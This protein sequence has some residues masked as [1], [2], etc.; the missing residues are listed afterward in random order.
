M[1]AMLPLT[2]ALLAATLLAPGAAHAYVDPGTGSMVL[3]G[4]IAAVLGL[5]LTVKLYWRKIRKRLTGKSSR[6][7]ETDADQ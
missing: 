6:D 4:I 7:N 5:G 2:L 3:Q 1:S